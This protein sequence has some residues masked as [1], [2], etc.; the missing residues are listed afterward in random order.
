MKYTSEIYRA[1]ILSYQKFIVYKQNYQTRHTR[2]CYICTHNDGITNTLLQ[3]Q[4]LEYKSI[5]HEEDINVCIVTYRR[6]MYSFRNV[7]F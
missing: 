2:L 6:S 4:K 7:V 5:V 1:I 3:E